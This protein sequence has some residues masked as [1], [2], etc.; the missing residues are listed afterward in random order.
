VK[1]E[2]SKQVRAI[3]LA[4]KRRLT[5]SIDRL[6][7]DALK[8]AGDAAGELTDV[9]AEHMADRGSDNFMRD[10]KIS[11]LQNTEAELC[12]VNRAIEMLEAGTYGQCERCAEKIP[13]KRLKAL[14][15]ARL[16]LA[17]QEEEERY[18]AQQEF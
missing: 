14:P 11:V 3:L 7:E 17:F 1:A 8:T 18:N 15:F 2:Q 5:D 13:A 16:C 4:L 12:D 10:V 9:P 6:E